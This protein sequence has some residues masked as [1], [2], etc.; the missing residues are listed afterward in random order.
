MAKLSLIQTNF[1]AGELSP[2]LLGRVD[3][4]RYQNGVKRLENALVAVQGG[5]MR[6]WGTEFITEVKDSAKQVR[7]IPYVF[8]RTQ[9]Y[10]IEFGDK[11]CR[12]Y[13]NNGE[14]LAEIE[15]PYNEDVLF[16]LNYVQGADTMFIA[17]PDTPIYRLRRVT[18]KDWTLAPAP[19]I[20]EPYDEVGEYPDTQITIDATKKTATTAVAYWL[21][22]DK[23]RFINYG[24]G[25]AE[26]TAVLGANV[27]NINIVTPFSVSVLPA[28]EW[29]LDGS[30]LAT[31]TPSIASTTDPIYAGSTVTL[32][33]SANG[34]RLSDVGKYIRITS[35]TKS[36]Y[37]IDRFNSA[38]SVTATCI[39][40]PESKASAPAYSW[41]LL[42]TVWGGKYGYPSAVTLF[43]QR[44]FCGGTKERPQT[45]WMSKIA[46]YLNFQLSTEDDDAAAFN[47]SS[48]QIN[49]ILH[50]SQAKKPIVLTYGGEFS[51]SGSATK[52]AITPTNITIANES[53]YG[54][55]HVK[56]A[57]IGNELIYMQRGG[58]KLLGM[59]FDASRDAFTSQ[60]LSIL[61]EHV[62]ESGI[63]E[64]AYQQEPYSILW[65]VRN[66][67]QIAT[68]TIDK[69][70]D[71]IG[72]AR[73]ITDGCYKSII[74]LPSTDGTIDEVWCIVERKIGGQAVKYIERFKQAIYT[75]S[76]KTFT[77]EQG[78]KLFTGLDH[79]EGKTVDIVAD[80]TV[81]QPR[82]V[83][84]GQI[85][86]ERTAKHVVIGLPYSTQIELLDF[87]VQGALG[88]SQG[89]KTRTG[90][91][92]LRL[93]D[94]IGCKV[95]GDYIA[96]RQLG[97]NVLDQPT[98][99]FTGD[100]RLESL[101]WN[102]TI[103][104]EQDQPLPFYLL[105]VIRK[106]TTNDG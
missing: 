36:L 70:Q 45:I 105:A 38:V 32:T 41:S 55:N 37:K 13:N 17:H 34:F 64:M 1:T 42:S 77:N 78:Q 97:Q 83:A 69:D 93:K 68:M 72:W 49:N 95:N 2:L 19:F 88:T 85:E 73:Q 14:Y 71:V 48:D 35:S 62:T 106:V 3:I 79:L 4:A 9:A 43:E 99:S 18:E 86:I 46:E 10:V 16:S 25:I 101:G 87:E 84:N 28:K 24:T 7:L 76:S 8:N 92:V 39:T 94:T 89:N 75:H 52:A 90:E 26:I 33:L 91:V 80:G 103:T 5:A 65:L 54:C 29:Q 74:T 11:Y 66:D 81:F 100:H 12:I 59:G 44:L 96:F 27:V 15:S 23:G 51:L 60:N 50:L 102:N 40:K 98:E 30:P 56:P 67:G 61:S 31:I 104:I 82:V 20:T 58:T 21:A 6:T 57:R 22:A 47:M 63:V 53:A